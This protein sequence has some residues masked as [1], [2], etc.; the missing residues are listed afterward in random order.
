M[1]MTMTAPI[2]TPEQI[3]TVD[4][5]SWTVVPGRSNLDKDEH[6]AWAVTAGDEEQYDLYFE[7]ADAVHPRQVAEFIVEAV[8]AHAT[9]LRLNAAFADVLRERERLRTRPSGADL[10]ELDRSRVVAMMAQLGKLAAEAYEPAPASEQDAQTQRIYDEVTHLAALA[11]SWLEA[12]HARYGA[13]G[14]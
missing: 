5:A 3:G 7:V 8:Q 6:G 14:I 11:V 1:V 4:L 13:D 2:P 10:Y 9:Q 12:I